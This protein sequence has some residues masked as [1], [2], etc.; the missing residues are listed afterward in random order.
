MPAWRNWSP[1]SGA[2]GPVRP[3]DV[4]GPAT[5][6]PR[7]LRSMGHR[8]RGTPTG[9]SRRERRT[10]SFRPST[11]SV[12]VTRPQ[13]R[14][15]PR[16]STRG[17]IWPRSRPCIAYS[18]NEPRCESAEPRPA[19]P[20]R[21][22]PSSWPKDPTR[23]GAGISRNWRVPT[24]G[25]GFSS[26]QSSTSTAATSSDGWWRARSRPPWPSSSSLTPSI[27]TACKQVS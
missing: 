11:R 27:V 8:P 7:S 14:S 18:E 24:S 3:W 4:L 12:S 5:I 13:P 19:G 17:P 25:P 22:S 23:S 2:G 1:S 15:G 10:P 21:L 16:S 6:G 9:P 20:R 26:T